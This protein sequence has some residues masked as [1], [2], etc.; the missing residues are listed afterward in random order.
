MTRI[1]VSL[2]LFLIGCAGLLSVATSM[3]EPERF[4]SR[5]GPRITIGT[6]APPLSTHVSVDYL[7]DE[8]MDITYSDVGVQ[9]ILGWRGEASMEV[10]V[11]I[12]P[13]N[14]D[15]PIKEEV[16]RVVDNSGINFATT[17]EPFTF[18]QNGTNGFTLEL[19]IPDDAPAGE[20]TLDWT[21]SVYMA[22]A[23]DDAASSTIDITFDDFDDLD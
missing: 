7:G 18:A 11:R 19:S 15:D 21:V 8:P 10:T 22:F 12:V 1:G 2:R 5:Q 16:V 9:G 14:P 3:I 23:D 20:L 6:D 13:D 4:E 17:V